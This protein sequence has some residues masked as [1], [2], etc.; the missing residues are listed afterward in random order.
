VRIPEETIQ[1]INRKASII[2]VVSEHLTL[3]K[4]GSKYWGLCP[5]HNEKTA[6]FSVDEEKNL[7]YCFGCHKGGSLFTF[8]MEVEGL[9]F[10]EAVKKMAEKSGVTLPEGEDPGQSEQHKRER[11]VEELYGKLIKTFHHFLMQ[12]E[13]GAAARTYLSDRGIEKH[14]IEAF[15]LGYVP[16]DRQ[17]LYNFL[18]AK[19]YS[20]SFLATTGLFSA[21][22]PEFSLFSNRLIFPIHNN[23]GIPVAFGGRKLEPGEP[24]YINSP[25][26][27][28][29]RKRETLYGLSKVLPVIR[30]QKKCF[31]V[32]GY[33][34]VL[35]LFQA[36]VG[37]AV[38]PLGT[39]LTV[40]QAR[41]LKRYV[42]EVH[43][44]FDGDSAGMDAA[45]KSIPVL[46]GI[47]METKVIQLPAGMDPAD[48]FKKE[49]SDSLIKTAKYSINSFEYLVK[50]ALN[51]ANA[52][53]P[54][55]EREVVSAVT[56]YINSI[57]SSVKREGCIRYLS[58]TL[59]ID[60]A[61][62][63]AD[64]RK[65][66]GGASFLRKEV[67]SVQEASPEPVVITPDLFLMLAVIANRS[68]YIYVRSVLSID[69]LEDKN[70]RDIYL[71]LEEA[72]RND[73]DNVETLIQRLDQQELK[74]LVY[75]KLSREE[76]SVNGEEIIRDGVKRLRMRMLQKQ[77][78]K[79]E[80]EIRNSERDGT[81]ISRM[82]ELVGEKI[83]LDQELK[84]G[85][86]N[87]A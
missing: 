81:P 20:R 70:A 71:A 4:K 65:A 21:K 78:M 31:L 82:R 19:N 63:I 17:W 62:I 74:D 38:A 53:K 45:R 9:S 73:E 11:A 85:K 79:V 18:L 32:E 10:I 57:D 44:F 49:G 68:Y 30:K 43:L 64:M 46:E 72:F 83:Y 36:G 34:D 24:K 66:K 14:T 3:E 54:G 42:G 37:G 2:D 55:G 41:L 22:R 60:A 6:S 8:L 84:K 33:F 26:T 15:E 50:S 61:S 56:P 77:R 75:E 86:G 39:A 5:F 47:G 13:S 67:G 25:E 59:Q 51:K 1:E 48:I 27:I 58:E 29:F 7:Y 28:I 87:N 40:E 12:S 76:F 23:R 80:A 16:A 52:R 69:D 35:A